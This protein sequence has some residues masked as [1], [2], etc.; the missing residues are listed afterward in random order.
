MCVC[1]C[2]CVCL[3]VFDRKDMMVECVGEV[4]GEGVDCVCVCVCVCL[5]VCLCLARRTW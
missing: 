2:V 4:L 3:S 5:F 1:V